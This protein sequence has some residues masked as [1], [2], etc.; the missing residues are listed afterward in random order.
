MGLPFIHFQPAKFTSNLSSR[1]KLIMAVKQHQSGAAAIFLY[2][3]ATLLL[4]GSPEKTCKTFCVFMAD[5][6]SAMVKVFQGKARLFL[7][8]WES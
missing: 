5:R 4:A 1:N 6:L 2:S 8:V 3:A 7:F